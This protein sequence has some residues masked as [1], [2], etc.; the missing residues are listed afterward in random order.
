[1]ANSQLTPRHL[2]FAEGI[3]SGK[4]PKDAYIEA[5]YKSRGMSAHSAANRMLKNVDS[6]AF[7]ESAN[8]K[9]IAKAELSADWVLGRLKQI[10]EG[11]RGS[12]V[13]SLELL[14][15]YLRLWTDGHADKVNRTVPGNATG[16]PARPLRDFRFQSSRWAMRAVR[17]RTMAP[18]AKAPKLPWP[19]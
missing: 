17:P 14:G 8:S 11:D 13:R 16:R 4:V 18:P 2:K 3:L 5:G 12:A 1:M 9:A 7:L 6:S 15:K 19:G 10:A